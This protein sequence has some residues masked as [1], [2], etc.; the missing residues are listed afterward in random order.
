MHVFA[1]FSTLLPVSSDCPYCPLLSPIGSPS[2][3]YAF[4]QTHTSTRSVF[5]RR[6]FLSRGVVV[7]FLGQLCCHRC[8]I[9]NLVDLKILDP[10]LNSDQMTTNAHLCTPYGVLYYEYILRHPNIT[11]S[12]T[13][14]DPNGTHFIA[15]PRLH[16]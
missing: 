5:S 15:G 1:D 10:N 3:N 8:L 6:I 13:Q 11:R 16:R 2:E 9:F 7:A 14:S 4:L 12:A